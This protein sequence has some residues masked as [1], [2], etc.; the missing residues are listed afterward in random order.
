MVEANPTDPQRSK[1]LQSQS[2]QSIAKI[3][4]SVPRLKPSPPPRKQFCFSLLPL[5]H[6]KVTTYFVLTS[7][8]K[9]GMFSARLF[10]NVPAVL[11]ENWDLNDLS[12]L[13]LP[14]RLPEPSEPL[15]RRVEGPV[16]LSFKS[17]SSRT[18]NKFINDGFVSFLF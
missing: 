13:R 18:H 2:N 1:R 7:W 17:A 16:P 5:P 12:L 11:S 14:P 9:S 4:T 15:R 3:N 6:P 10:L 8:D